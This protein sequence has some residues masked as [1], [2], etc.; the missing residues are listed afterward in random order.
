M[1]K[2]TKNCLHLAGWTCN[3]LVSQALRRRPILRKFGRTSIPAYHI[4]WLEDKNNAKT[5]ETPGVCRTLAGS[6]AQIAIVCCLE[7]SG[8]DLALPYY[9]PHSLM[10]PMHLEFWPR[11]T[12]PL[13]VNA[14]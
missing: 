2:L 7:R 8:R 14:A 6:H 3:Q 13:S 9:L 5:M 10:K 12:I 1:Q 11:V 4:G